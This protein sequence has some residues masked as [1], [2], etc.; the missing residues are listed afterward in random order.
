MSESPRKKVAMQLPRRAA[1]ADLSERY[2]LE[3]EALAPV[4]DIV[5]VESPTAEAF[6]EAAADCDAVIT[7]WGIRFDEAVISRLDKCVVIGLG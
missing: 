2:A 6:A 1:V 5:E 3:L 4:A 7:S